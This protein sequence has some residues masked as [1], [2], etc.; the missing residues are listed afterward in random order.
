MY[1]KLTERQLEYRRRWDKLKELARDGN[2]HEFWG[3]YADYLEWSNV[4][5]DSRRA[6]HKM[7]RMA[8]RL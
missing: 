8:E 6:L 2:I 3:R 1:L 7:A 4:V 5:S